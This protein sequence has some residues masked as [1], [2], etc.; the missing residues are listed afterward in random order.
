MQFRINQRIYDFQPNNKEQETK[1]TYHLIKALLSEINLD[2]AKATRKFNKDYPDAK[3]T[4]QNLSNK[5]YRD[6]LRVTEFFKL[7][8]SLGY[9][10]SFDYGTNTN[11]FVS[12][13]KEKSLHDLIVAG[14]ADCESINFKSIIIVGANAKQAAQW[15]KDNLHSDMKELE[16]TMLMLDTNR[17]FEVKC[18]PIAE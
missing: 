11:D 8:D 16:E 17:R 13:N 10:I 1:L 7:L 2:L 12:L 4:S 18:N 6:S 3:T 5:L 14:F 15:Y 9:M